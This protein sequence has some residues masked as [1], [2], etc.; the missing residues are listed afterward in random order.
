MNAPERIIVTG[1]GYPCL[2]CNGWIGE[3][4]EAVRTQ[5]GHY[6][7]PCWIALHGSEVPYPE[8]QSQGPEWSEP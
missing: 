4:H 2:G 8:D 5:N 1:L 3:H 7:E 6:H